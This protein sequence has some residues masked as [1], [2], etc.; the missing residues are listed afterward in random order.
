M[1]RHWGHR[2]AAHAAKKAK[3]HKSRV[4]RAK[5]FHV[6]RKATHVR[7]VNAPKGW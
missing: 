7:T 3:T 6:G 5:D 1:A 2:R 4:K